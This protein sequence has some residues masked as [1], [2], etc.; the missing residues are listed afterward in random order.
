MK[1]IYTIGKMTGL[2]MMRSRFFV[3]FGFLTL[4]FII[5]LQVLQQLDF[6]S[7]TSAFMINL[8]FGG[9]LFFGSLLCIF[10]SV[11]TVYTEIENRTLIPLLTKPVGWTSI[12]LGKFFALWILLGLYLSVLS[13]LIYAFVW[14]EA[15]EEMLFSVLAFGKVMIAEWIFFGV[16]IAAGMLIASYA[17]S[18]LF[19]MMMLAMFWV[20]GHLQ[21]LLQ[22]LVKQEEPTFLQHVIGIVQV[23]IPNFQLFH[24]SDLLT[25][26]SISAGMLLTISGA[27]SIFIISYLA[28]SRLFFALKEL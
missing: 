16:L 2:E 25:R 4:L 19:A 12:I 7:S 26:G 14:F 10:L 3:G 15:K 18:G 20:V 11:Q 5:S 27:G 8:G 24:L 17:T 23:L 22:S 9:I 6:G 13:F 21:Y 28:L 1:K